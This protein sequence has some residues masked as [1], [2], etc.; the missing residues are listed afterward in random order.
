MLFIVDWKNPERPL[1]K[2]KLRNT[3]DGANKTLQQ[4]QK[5]WPMCMKIIDSSKIA[6]ADIEEG[7]E[8]TTLRQKIKGKNLVADGD[9]TKDQAKKYILICIGTKCG[10]MQLWTVNKM[11]MKSTLEYQSPE[12]L[13][14]GAITS[15]DAYANNSRERE[16]I[17]CGTESGEIIQ[18]DLKKKLDE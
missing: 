15:I 7:S 14:Y 1:Q 10:R 17:I 2:I 12:G 16:E 11:G 8:I 6:K 9:K 18:F 4:Q 13:S 5:A 3:F